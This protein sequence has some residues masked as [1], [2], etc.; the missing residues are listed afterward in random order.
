ML[1][2]GPSNQI[3]IHI[4]I[5]PNFSVVWRKVINLWI[6]INVNNPRITVL[7]W[8]W[9]TKGT[10]DSIAKLGSEVEINSFDMMM[11]N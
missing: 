2:N 6:K 8:W 4:L 10:P 11:D 7:I 1:Q 3:N 9:I 5:S